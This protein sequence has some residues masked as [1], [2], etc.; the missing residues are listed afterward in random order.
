MTV[1]TSGKVK[2]IIKEGNF[3]ASE[4][5]NLLDPAEETLARARR[6]GAIEETLRRAG[7]IA[8]EAGKKKI[9]RSCRQ[10]NRRRGRAFKEAYEK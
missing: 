9:P 4:L 6:C 1:G 5:R 8:G 7:R 3:P 10:G 2:A